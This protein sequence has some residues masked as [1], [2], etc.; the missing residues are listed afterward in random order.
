MQTK[1]CF[2]LLHIQYACFPDIKFPFP[3]MCVGTL[4]CTMYIPQTHK[5]NKKRDINNAFEN[6][7]FGFVFALFSPTLWSQ[8]ENQLTLFYNL[9]MRPF[10][11]FALSPPRSRPPIPTPQLAPYPLPLAFPPIPSSQPTP[12]SWDRRAV[13]SFSPTIPA[14]IT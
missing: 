5:P 7:F 10:Q 3:Q 1:T 9:F 6:W 13:G 2:F 11:P 8:F 4:Q 14:F 12:P